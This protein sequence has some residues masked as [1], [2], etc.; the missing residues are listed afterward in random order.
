M[1]R[2]ILVLGACCLFQFFAGCAGTR[3]VEKATQDHMEVLTKKKNELFAKGYFAAVATEVSK[4]LQAAIDKAALSARAEISRSIETK[5]SDYQKKMVS[6][7][8][9]AGNEE[10]LRTYRNVTKSVTVQSLNGSLIE[11][12]PYQE[13]YS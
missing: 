6:D 2:V 1:K 13:K 5:L 12:S 8:G 7:V 11:D 10:F 4:D 9:E 3:K